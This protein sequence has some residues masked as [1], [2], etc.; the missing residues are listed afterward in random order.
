[1]SWIFGRVETAP[2]A[3]ARADVARVADARGATVAVA[4]IVDASISCVA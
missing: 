4:R 2:R 3:G 1:V